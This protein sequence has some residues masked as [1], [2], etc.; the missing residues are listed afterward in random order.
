V[1]DD[2]VDH[3]ATALLL[4][5]GHPEPAVSI[6]K[7]VRHDPRPVEVMIGAPAGQPELAGWATLLGDTGAAIP[8][9][10]YL[11]ERL[12]PQWTWPPIQVVDRDPA[13]PDRFRV[14][15]AR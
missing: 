6:V 15:H 1:C 4:L 12:S 14:L 7:A 9:L 8:F 5:A 3:H 13:E 2:V 10:R 11:P